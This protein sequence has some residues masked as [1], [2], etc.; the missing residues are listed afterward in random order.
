MK[1]I[2]ELFPLGVPIVVALVITVL[3][4][5]GFS[6]S[7]LLSPGLQM[8]HSIGLPGPACYP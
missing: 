5:P 8:I 3:R 1:Y 6:P 4:V 7:K 2:A